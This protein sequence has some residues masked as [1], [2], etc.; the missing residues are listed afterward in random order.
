MAPLENPALK[1]FAA[2]I[3]KELTLAQVLIRRT[4]PSE[5]QYELR[6]VTDRAQPPEALRLVQPQEAR[7]VAQ[8]TATGAFRPLKSAPNLQ[9]GWRIGVADEAALETALNRIY[10]GAI[11]DWYAAQQA[12][13]PVTGF[14]EFTR[15]QSG[16]YRITTFLNDAD[17]ARV[18]QAGCAPQFCLKRRLWTVPGLQADAAAEKSLIPCLEPCA[19]LL[20]FA[21]KA[22]RLS[23]EES[24]RFEV[25]PGEAATLEA[26]LRLALARPEPV[27]PEADFSSPANPRRVQLVLE[28]LRP[29]L[30][31]AGEPESESE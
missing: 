22:V 14:H 11:A 28:K 6:H 20:E 13:P 10:P 2:H 29:M 25:A 7:S 9:T 5:G 15:R 27:V 21:R 12:I 17:A 30:Q 8:F 4:G 23:Q 3:G 19:V 31:P 1:A 24:V 16:M 18:I 26:A